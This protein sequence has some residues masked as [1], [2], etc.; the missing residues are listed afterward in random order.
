M[1]N[2]P[3][4]PDST[5]ACA[6]RSPHPLRLL[7][8]AQVLEVTGLGKTKIYELQSQGRFR[9]ASKLRPTVLD[10]WR[11]RCRTG[12]PAESRS[13][14]HWVGVGRAG[15]PT[16]LTHPCRL[17]PTKRAR[18]A[19][20]GV[21]TLHAREH[22]NDATAGVAGQR[23]APLAGR[24]IITLPVNHFRYSA[25]EP[26]FYSCESRV[27]WQV[28]RIGRPERKGMRT[29]FLTDY[30]NL[31]TLTEHSEHQPRHLAAVP[32]PLLAHPN[33]G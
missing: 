25:A 2:L 10:G 16:R 22:R 8:L 15:I 18:W 11:V 17:A 33:A 31:T 26:R 32:L 29:R 3:I 5:Q 4:T 20:E 13:A 19:P 21:S 12:S 23:A 14:L 1:K 27:S 7:H 6:L 28:Y 24:A 30:R 9:C